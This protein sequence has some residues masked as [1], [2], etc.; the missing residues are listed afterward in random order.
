M[1]RTGRVVLSRL[2]YLKLKFEVMDR[3]G[4]LC[5]DCGDEYPTDLHHIKDRKMGGAGR[6]DSVANVKLLCR[7]CHERY[8]DKLQFSVK[9]DHAAQAPGRNPTP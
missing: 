4:G 5:A 6:D 7:P 3:Q 9:E 2:D 1:T 8:S